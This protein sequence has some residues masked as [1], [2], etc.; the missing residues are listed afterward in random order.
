MGKQRSAHPAAT[1]KPASDQEPE[2]PALSA[3]AFAFAFVV[4]ILAF[5]FAFLLAALAQNMGEDRAT[6]AATTQYPAADQKA[7]DPAMIFVFA[8]VFTFV[9]DFIF[10]FVFVFLLVMLAHEMRNKQAA[11]P[12]TAQQT[13]RNQ[14]LQDAMLLVASLLAFTQFLAFFVATAFTQQACEKQA[15]HTP[16][17][18]AAADC[19]F[20]KF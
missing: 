11:D 19:Q 15:P 1:Q 16:T 7:Q 8:L 6:N 12:T 18:Q 10:V 2:H 5:V 3:S 14:K 17:A 4:L 13:P 9:V 20:L